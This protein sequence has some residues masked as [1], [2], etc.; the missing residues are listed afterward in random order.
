MSGAFLKITFWYCVQ[1]ANQPIACMRVY[2]LTLILLV[3]LFSFVQAQPR[4]Q[5]QVVAE[6]IQEELKID[7]ILDESVWE[8]AI[9]TSPFTNKWPIDSGRAEAQTEVRLLF[10]DNYLYISAIA[11]Q[12]KEDLIIQSLKRDQLDAHWGSENFG[13]AIDPLSQK[14]TGFLFAV[15]AGGAQ[16]DAML[17][18]QGAWTVMNENWDNKWFSAVRTEADRWIIEMAIPF[19]ALR[20]DKDVANWSINFIRTDKKRNFF[21]TWSQV[22]L[23]FNGIDLGHYG[24][25][26]FNGVFSPNQ[27]RV[28][29][30]PYASTS[31]TQN[32]EE[33]EA[34]K[35][36]VGVGLDAK[37][38]L[39]SSLNL[40]LTYKPDFSNVEVDRQVT[41]LTRFSILFPERRNFFLENADLFSNYGSWQVKPFFSRK[42]G[43][44]NG[45]AIPIQAGARI[46]GNVTKSLRIGIMDI[47]TDATETIS[48]NNYF[49][50]SA[51]QGLLK[52]SNIKLFAANR[53]TSKTVEGDV[54]DEYNRTMGAE[55]Q[56]ISGDGKL[57]SSVRAHMAQTPERLKENEYLSTQTSYNTSKFYGGLMLEKVGENYVNDFGFVPRLYN[58]DAQN[59]TTIRIGH[60]NINPWF[61][62]LLRPKKHGINV[63]EPN[64]WSLINYTTDGRFMERVSSL[65]LN[66]LFK[67]TA[68]FYVEAV[69]T[70]SQLLLACDVINSDT[71]LPVG[72]YTY[73]Q[74]AVKYLTD[75]RKRFTTDLSYTQGQ[76]YNGSRTELGVIL[77]ARVQ[78]WGNF[79]VSYLQNDVTLP[80]EYGRAN[81]KL[82]GP[83]TEISFRNNIWWTTFLQYNTQAENFNVNSRLQWRFKPMSDLFVVYTDNYTTGNFRVKNRGV[84]VKLTYWLNI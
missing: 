32:F 82:I 6:K 35:Q 41:N 29:L 30:V 20:F 67:S 79:G 25:L 65:N 58:Y 51:Q 12:K 26:S 50:A 4:R 5:M 33:G 49:V 70:D 28:T 84:V 11:H 38:A 81:F 53:E 19:S 80:S 16:L 54:S 10:D 78:P 36:G 62:L 76:F 64:T 39:T 22:P 44:Q 17:T 47:Q 7:G 3:A 68:R 61:G 74:Y 9:V 1:A 15:N 57:T 69:N 18:L 75:R 13:V 56:Y 40:D 34:L 24:S 14:N 60:Y 42:I 71:P 27:S 46:T 31:S 72:R 23:Q 66:I 83:K 2:I 48:A 73:T 8:K 21:S 77:N 52:R 55:F 63:I 43:I 59:D 45:E 37:I